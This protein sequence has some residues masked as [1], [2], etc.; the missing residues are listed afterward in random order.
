LIF[1]EARVPV[2]QRVGA[3]NEGWAVAK[4]LMRFARQSNTTS[5]LVRRAMAAA[6]R[7]MADCADAAL[8]ARR[9]G[10]EIELTA[11][12]A[13]ELRLLGGPQ[14]ADEAASS[15]LKTVA[16]ELHQRVAELALDA[17]GTEAFP[18]AARKYLNARAAS[19][20]SGTNETHRNLLAAHLIGRL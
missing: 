17:A 15:L 5:G 1:E 12:E 9:A 19:I 7:A 20:Y 2:A 10:L 3:E 8:L 14:A 6:K 11:L 18:A 16:T 4:L 13:L